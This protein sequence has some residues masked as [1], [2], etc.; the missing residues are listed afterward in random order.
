M[1]GLTVAVFACAGML[2]ASVV[3]A[4]TP[5]PAFENLVPKLKPGQ[6]LLITSRALGMSNT[7][8][9][10]I[11]ASPSEI[12]FT[13]KGQ[14]RQVTPDQLSALAVVRHRVTPVG[15]LIGGL[16]GLGVSS[17]L[18]EALRDC[19]TCG[20]DGAVSGRIIFTTMGAIVG[21]ALQALE[22]HEDW[23]YVSNAPPV[24]I[25]SFVTRTSKGVAVT[26][27]F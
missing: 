26:I 27:R 1:R 19:D 23:L 20:E 16:I 10:L 4:Q 14:D 17:F 15:P 2:Q 5:A 6:T 25:T 13:F 11:E 12:R 3:H 7:K 22:A 18:L 9:T 8:V 24:V 21:A